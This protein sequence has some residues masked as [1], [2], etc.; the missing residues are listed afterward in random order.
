MFY[1]KKGE[2]S[3]NVVTRIS[4]WYKKIKLVLLKLNKS[5]YILQRKYQL[6]S[7]GR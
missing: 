5:Q 1:V 2:K 6:N 3:S 4:L 7:S